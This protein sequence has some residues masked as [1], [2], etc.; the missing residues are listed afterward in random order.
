M[1]AKLTKNSLLRSL[2]ILI[3]CACCFISCNHLYYHPDDKIYIDPYRSFWGGS[4]LP[5]KLKNEITL[6]GLY[7]PKKKLGPCK[8]TILVHFHGNAQNLSAH[9]PLLQWVKEVGMDYFI[10]DYPGYGKSTGKTN[11]ET[12]HQ[13]SLEVLQIILNGERPEFKDKS[14]VFYGQSLGGA[15]MSHSLAMIKDSVQLK[16]IRKIIIESSFSSYREVASRKLKLSWLTWPLQ[17]IP[18]VFVSD[19]DSLGLKIQKDVFPEVL[20]VHSKQDWVVPYESGKELYSA[21]RAPKR[22]WSYLG[23]SHL[24]LNAFNDYRSRLTKFM[25]E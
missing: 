21:W 16:R 9:F 17:W 8:D 24:Q 2:I 15:I 14:I 25:C 19:E 10:F 13:T 18:Y 1:L 12:I 6:D 4:S 22:F 5:L 3:L 11:R 7:I 23:F 20:V